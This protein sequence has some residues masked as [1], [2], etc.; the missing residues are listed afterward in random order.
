MDFNQ[1]I[2]PQ[3]EQPLGEPI[4]PPSQVPGSTNQ[5]PQSAFD[6]VITSTSGSALPEVSPT[7]NS[8][9]NIIV[10]NQQ[11]PSTNSQTGALLAGPISK[12]QSPAPQI[13]IDPKFIAST[14]ATRTD[15]GAPQSQEFL[16]SNPAMQATVFNKGTSPPPNQHSGVFSS[17]F[18]SGKKRFALSKRLFILL[19]PLLLIIGGGVAAYFGII[20]PKKPQNI[21]HKSLTNMG[22][23]TDKLI[24]YSST[25][26]KTTKGL[27]VEGNYSFSGSTNSKGTISVD[28]YGQ[29]GELKTNFGLDGSNISVDLRSIMADKATIPDYYLRVSGLKLLNTHFD[30][31]LSDDESVISG[32]DNQWILI[33]QAY[34]KSMFGMDTS[35][36]DQATIT[37]KDI[38]AAEQAINDVNKKWLWTDNEDQAVLE[39]TKNIGKEKQNNRSVYHY[40]VRFNKSHTT[41][42]LKA[43]RDKFKTTD[44]YDAIKDSYLTYYTDFSD[45]DIENYTK[46][47]NESKDFDVWVDTRT[48]LFHKIRFTFKEGYIDIGQ[49]YQGGSKFPF[50]IVE[51]DK[52][53]GVTSDF[54]LQATLD[55]DSNKLMMK[56]T[57]VSGEE[58][59][60][61]DL[62][63]SQ[64]N[65]AT[66]IKAPSGA[67]SIN[68]MLTKLG[69]EEWITE[70]INDPDSLSATPTNAQDV[71]RQS[72]IK[73]LHSQIEAYYA[74]NGFYPKLANLNN[75]SWRTTNM[76]GLDSAALKDPQGTSSSIVSAP[77]VHAYAYEASTADGTDCS[78]SDKDCAQYILTATFSD[79]SEYIKYSLN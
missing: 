27:S 28:S 19:I 4:V 60:T 64:K 30:N 72:D 6:Q 49:D 58:K 75:S 23:G 76:R 53:D 18:G 20:V 32:I 25:L 3:P 16:N 39:V 57:N 50:S 35:V 26:Q 36:G 79:S 56:L 52:K 77:A 55:K 71:E 5:S 1:P 9:G 62:S 68:E 65:S 8:P 31:F 73:A 54:N 11:Q 51:H 37:Y 21:W 42:Y 41:Q 63:I 7:L 46:D 61:M 10:P 45:E 29:N 24:E 74:Q 22:L 2:T 59:F 69:L 70:D 78:D 12:E 67:K 34:I 33:N 43:L 14:F 15:L 40:S 17:Q 47:L 13:T 38:L 48:K 44:L 66:D